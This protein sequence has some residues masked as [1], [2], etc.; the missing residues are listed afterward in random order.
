MSATSDSVAL[1]YQLTEAEL[2]SFVG[3][4][5]ARSRLYKCLWPQRRFLLG[6]IFLALVLI[7]MM[8]FSDRAWWGDANTRFLVSASFGLFILTIIFFDPLFSS[9]LIRRRA[10]SGK[11]EAF[12]QPIRFDVTSTA[13][14]VTSIRSGGTQEWQTIYDIKLSRNG[15]LIYVLPTQAF[16]IPKRPFASEA[17]FMA[18]LTKVSELPRQTGAAP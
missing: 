7:A 9:L 2:A 13:L 4:A 6:L 12:L 14:K 8:V 10:R 5:Y 16:M 18:F 11:Y 15:A 3:E 1:E 17:D